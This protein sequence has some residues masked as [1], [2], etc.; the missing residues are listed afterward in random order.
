MA[1][2]LVHEV[3]IARPRGFDL[4]ED[5]LGTAKPRIRV[6][7]GGP[8][9]QDSVAN[10]LAAVSDTA[11]II[12]IHDAAR[13]FASAA[14]FERTIKAASEYGAAIAALPATDTVKQ[15]EATTGGGTAVVRATLPRDTVFL[16]QT[17]QAFRRDILVQ[18]IARHGE[19]Q[20]T[21]E[22][23][24]VERAGFP[25]HIVDGEVTNI[26]VTTPQDL[27]D[28][29]SRARGQMGAVMR[30]GTGYDLHRFVAGRQLIVGGVRIPFEL[31]LQGHSDADIVCH[32]VTDAV[33]GGAALGD[34]GRLFPDSDMQWK[35]A[36]SVK[37]L[38][39]AMERVRDAGYEVA[40]VD[41]TVIT[42]RPKLLPYLDEMRA[43]LASALGIEVS[44]VSIKGKTNETVGGIGRGEAMAC[45]AVALLHGR[46]E[47]RKDGST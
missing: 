18:A 42:E 39:V 17:P 32:A 44:A 46:V 24:L 15:A 28:A 12:V 3:V 43:N 37:L 19:G 10:A 30:I 5:W 2:A 13:P 8:R 16:A 35:G 29:R 26:K 20:A 21:D 41:V 11:D 14:L 23:M 6:V 34:I 36:D 9:R 7:D 33:L 22:A 45:H 25:V 40:N 27:R 4:S 38:R 31:G 1:C 47:A